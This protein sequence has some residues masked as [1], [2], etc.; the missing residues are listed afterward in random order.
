L[1]QRAHSYKLLGQETEFLKDIDKAIEIDPKNAQSYVIR[2]EHNMSKNAFQEAFDDVNKIIEIQPDNASAQYFRGIIYYNLK[3]YPEC[4]DDM[5]K[6]LALKTEENEIYKYL[7]ICSFKSNNFIDAIKYLTK[8]LEFGIQ[9]N[10]VYYYRAEAEFK[11]DNFDNSINDIS[12]AIYNN[13]KQ[14][15]YYILR[16]RDYDKKGIFDKA[17][18][19]YEKALTLKSSS[20]ILA[21][22]AQFLFKY[23]KYKLSLKDYS[24]A[25]SLDNMNAELYKQRGLVYQKL[26]NTKNAKSDFE[27][28]YKLNPKI[29]V[30]IEKPHVLLSENSSSS[31]VAS[32]PNVI[33]EETSNSV[34]QSK[35]IGFFSKL[36]KGNKNVENPIT[37]IE[38][39]KEETKPAIVNT[40]NKKINITSIFNRANINYKNKKYDIALEDLSKIIS[41]DLQYTQAYLLRANIYNELGDTDKA[42]QDL[43]KTIEL[44]QSSFLAYLKRAEIYFSLNND[45]LALADFIKTI[46]LNPKLGAGYIGIAKIHAKRGNKEKAIENYNL[47][48]KYDI[49]YGK[50]AD[51]EIKSLSIVS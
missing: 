30:P 20:E 16:A 22:K 45:D 41:Q 39:P 35:K 13:S 25:I 36:F 10:D 49:K 18:K 34:I 4:F 44:S 15:E 5:K 29:D 6:A 12:K 23:E 1:Q 17:N 40:I 46:E 3:K 37:K 26:N 38:Q 47:A 32:G 33:V 43:N 48:K 42:L 11:T 2:A 19:D 7:G 9:D 24:A 31:S 14:Y 27:Q 21:E 28:A 8:S 51:V 50:I